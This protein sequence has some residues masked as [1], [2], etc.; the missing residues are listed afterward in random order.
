M[1]HRSS[2]PR[3]LSARI[4]PLIA[5]LGIAALGLAACAKTDT[6]RATDSIAAAPAAAT[7]AEPAA[8]TIVARDYAYEA[9]DTITAGMVTLTLANKGPELHHVQLFRL[10]GGKSYADLQAG[11]KAMK[12]GA[13]MPPWIEEVAGPNSPAPGG[14]MSI[15]QELTPGNY[16]LVCLIPSPD[17]VPHVMKGMMKSLT[18]VPATNAVAAAPVA[19]IVVK[20]TDYAWE[21]S[22]AITSGKHVVRLENLAEQGHEMFIVRL[23]KGKTP[24]QVAEWAENPVGPPPGFPLGGSSSQAKGSVVYVPIDLEPGEYALI[25][26]IP[27]RKDGKPHYL[28]GMMKAFTVS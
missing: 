18:V 9:P 12:P 14:E 20:M 24:M 6:P 1:R 21:V 13:P 28:H 10:T 27:D 2:N 16:A 8:I 23:E 11:L 5:I 3:F 26:F 25:C 22:P 7:T 4:T 19:D 17:H 15:T